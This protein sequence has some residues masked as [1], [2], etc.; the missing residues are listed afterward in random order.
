MSNRNPLDY[1]INR[2][3]SSGYNPIRYIFK[4]VILYFCLLSCNITYHIFVILQY[5]FCNIILFQPQIAKIMLD[6]INFELI[7][8]HR[9]DHFE[10]KQGFE[11][12]EQRKRK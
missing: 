4:D 9:L 6:I 10:I 1:S 5:I 8:D 11:Y 7:L 12:C 3:L 2:P